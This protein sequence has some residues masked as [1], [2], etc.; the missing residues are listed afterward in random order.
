MI[1]EVINQWDKN[2]EKL[3]SYFKTTKQE[4]I[5]GNYL[6]IVK[7]LFELVLLDDEWDIEKITVVDDG[8]Y[9]GTQLFIIPK[10]TYQPSFDDYLITH[11]YYGSC[12]GCDTLESIRNYNDELPT[13][14]QVSEYMTLAL[15][16]I[17]KMQKLVDYESD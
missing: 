15:H 4:E 2:K 7:K 13:H 17:Q 16:L 11:T 9:Q 10:K 5:A 12:S 8:D 6:S 3:E 1:K 14:E